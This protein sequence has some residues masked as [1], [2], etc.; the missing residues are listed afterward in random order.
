MY[1]QQL[2]TNC[3]AQASYYI[4]SENEAVIID[5]IRDTSLYVDLL[6]ERNATLGKNYTNW[7][8]CALNCFAAFR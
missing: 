2:Y 6:Q 7:L 3:L 8:D 1:I 5:P 4:E